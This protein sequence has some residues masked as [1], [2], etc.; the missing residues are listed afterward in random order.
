MLFKQLKVCGTGFLTAQHHQAYLRQVVP[1]LFLLQ[2]I[3]IHCR[4]G[5]QHRDCFVGQSFQ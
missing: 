5:M 1:A 2:Q 4:R 3:A